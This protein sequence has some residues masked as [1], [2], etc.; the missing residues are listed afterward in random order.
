MPNSDSADSSTMR[1]GDRPTARAAIVRAQ[2][3]QIAKSSTVDDVL[4]LAGRCCLSQLVGNQAAA[5][6]GDPEGVHQMRVAIRRLGSALAAFRRAM[7]EHQYRST[8]DGLDWLKQALGTARNWDVFAT[9]LL[10]PVAGARPRDH[11]LA[12]LATA[13]AR[14]RQEAY[15]RVEEAIRSPRYSATITELT[16]WF[17]RH[18]WRTHA[19]PLLDAAIADVAPDLVDRQ[20]RSVRKRGRRFLDQSPMQRHKLRIAL[21]KLRYAIELLEDV[22]D[23]ARVATYR[24]RIK[25]LQADLGR[26]NDVRTAHGLVSEII[27]R[28]ADDD[29]AL[30]RTAGLVLGWHERGLADR[31][32]RTARHVRQMRRLPSF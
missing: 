29:P 2:P 24:K 1:Q 18:A 13:A 25:T 7:P 15:R 23:P 21:K 31:E 4:S 10:T 26:I 14:R 22:L 30:A 16:G 32:T 6:A 28:D 20:R 12:T 5:L 17:E 3:L 19:S 8:K 11:D 9:D 27:E